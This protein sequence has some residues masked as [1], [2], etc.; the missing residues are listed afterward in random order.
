MIEFRLDPNSTTFFYSSLFIF[1]SSFFLKTTVQL[2]MFTIKIVQHMIFNITIVQ[3][4]TFT[5]IQL[6]NVLR[7][8]LYKTKQITYTLSNAQNMFLF[9]PFLFF[10]VLT[11]RT[12]NLTLLLASI[13][14]HLLCCTCP[15]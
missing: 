2:M 7:L 13:F 3:R 9:V 8:Q 14:S 10:S 15:H 4:M 1:L 6:Y 5:I 11:S 12:Y